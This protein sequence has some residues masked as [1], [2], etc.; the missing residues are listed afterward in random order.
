MQDSSGK[1]EYEEL[2]KVMQKLGSSCG[3][4]E[5]KDVFVVRRA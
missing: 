2:T 3:A 1:I 4:A 5:V